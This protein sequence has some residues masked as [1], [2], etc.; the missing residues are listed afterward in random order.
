MTVE[1]A[2]GRNVF[3][4]QSGSCVVYKTIEFGEGNQVSKKRVPI[5][6]L[7]EGSIVGEECLFAPHKYHYTVR[8][9][10]NLIRVLVFKRTGSMTEFKRNRVLDNL[11][12]I[13]D[14]KE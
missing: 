3:L 14:S 10:T 9:E 2:I 6:R 12:A 7:G 8:V 13:F 5:C 1:E 4:I 11:K